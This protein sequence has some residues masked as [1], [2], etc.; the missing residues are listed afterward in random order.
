MTTEKHCKL[1]RCHIFA[2]VFRNLQRA[3]LRPPSWNLPRAND[4]LWLAH[5]NG[6]ALQVAIDV[7][8]GATCLATLR[9]VEDSSTLLATRNTTFLLHCRLQQW[10]LHVKLFWQLVMQRLRYKLQGKLPRATWPLAQCDTLPR[11]QFAFIAHRP[12]CFVISKITL[13]AIRSEA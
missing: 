5:F 12:S 8:H 2:I 10:V 7:S 3:F 6:I 4:A 9:K 1:Q 13:L 11:Q